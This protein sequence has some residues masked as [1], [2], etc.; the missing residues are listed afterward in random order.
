MCRLRVEDSVRPQA[1]AGVWVWTPWT[2]HVAAQPLISMSYHVVPTVTKCRRSRGVRVG[3]VG[4]FSR[5]TKHALSTSTS[6]KGQT[7]QRSKVVPPLP[8]DE[9]ERPRAMSGFGVITDDSFRPGPRWVP[10][11]TKFRSAHGIRVH[12]WSLLHR[13]LRVSLAHL[14][15][16]SRMAF[17]A[18]LASCTL[19]YSAVEQDHPDSQIAVSSSPALSLTLCIHYA[20]G[21]QHAHMQSI[22][23]CNCYL[24]STVAGLGLARPSTDLGLY[25]YSSV[26][27]LME[28]QSLQPSRGCFRIPDTIS[29][30]Q[31]TCGM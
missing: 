29:C 10:R 1:F 4:D 18:S 13:P 9:K 22:D 30:Y 16:L 6:P 15:R 20:C 12:P 28:L 19:M 21:G 7:S 27:T 17:F 3:Q 14:C 8:R 5:K 25:P 24:R 11:G 26:S 31:K 23:P 2:G